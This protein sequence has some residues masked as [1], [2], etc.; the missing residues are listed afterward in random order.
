MSKQVMIHELNKIV[1]LKEDGDLLISDPVTVDERRQYTFEL[2]ENGLI[3]GIKKR[4]ISRRDPLISISELIELYKKESFGHFFICHVG[5]DQIRISIRNMD[6]VG[7][8]IKPAESKIFPAG[9]V[10][11][12]NV[13]IVDPTTVSLSWNPPDTDTEILGYEVTNGIDGWIPT[14]N[15]EYVFIGLTTGETYTFNVRA[16]NPAGLGDGTDRELVIVCVHQYCDCGKCKKCEDCTC[17]I[18]I[19]LEL[20]DGRIVNGMTAA[21][22]DACRT[23][24]SFNSNITIGGV[25]FRRDQ[26]SKIWFGDDF[27]LTSLE[28]FGTSF[29][30]LIYLNKIPNTVRNLK[31]FLFGCRN[32]NHP[33][34]IPDSVTGQDCLNGFLRECHAFNQ[35]I[36]IPDGVTGN[37]CLMNFLIGCESFNHPITIPDSVTGQDCLNGF[38]AHCTVFNQPITIPTGIINIHSSSLNNFL[39]NCHSMISTITVNDQNQFSWIFNNDNTLSTTDQNV[40][41]YRAGIPI[42]D[43]GAA[44]FRVKFPNRTTSPFRKLLLMGESVHDPDD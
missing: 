29:I 41:M 30:N 39:H 35:P 4:R 43:T 31:W 20:T 15:T 10:Q 19:T 11:N 26:V 23:I 38:L 37:G 13:S 36:T 33:I 40:P 2:M 17:P 25:T 12:L 21:D 32:F 24:S 8:Y 1:D 22:V 3:T 18:L 14:E 5:T 44:Q 9:P 6:D 28:N 42:N 16:D 27:N 34:T 7:R